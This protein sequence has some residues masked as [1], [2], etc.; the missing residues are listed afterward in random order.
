MVLSF[1]VIFAMCFFPSHVFL[2]WFYFDPNSEENFNAF[3]NYVRIIGFCL[4]FINSCINPITL[5]TLS[6]TFRKVIP[7]NRLLTYIVPGDLLSGR[8]RFRSGEAL[9]DSDL[10]PISWDKE[11]LM[12]PNPSLLVGLLTPVFRESFLPPSLNEW[13]RDG[14]EIEEGNNLTFGN[15]LQLLVCLSLLL[16][17]TAPPDMLLRVSFG[18]KVP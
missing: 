3:W 8:T 18:E 16:A 13:G 15:L 14:S 9:L 6:G 2:L 11:D 1:V 4:G 7:Q 12:L 10:I 5:Y 17:L